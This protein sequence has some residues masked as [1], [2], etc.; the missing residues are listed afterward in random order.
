DAK[1]IVPLLMPSEQRKRFHVDETRLVV[2]NTVSS[3]S[4]VYQCVVSNEVGVASSSAYV[5]IRDSAPVFPRQSM[6]RKMF[7]VNGSSV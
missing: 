7:T 5:Q 2:N 3:D 4:G 6:P 1:P